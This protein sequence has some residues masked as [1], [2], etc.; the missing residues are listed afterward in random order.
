MEVSSG[1]RTL[2]PFILARGHTLPMP[3][4]LSIRRG[5]MRAQAGLCAGTSLNRHAQTATG[6]CSSMRLSKPIRRRFGCGAPSAFRSL[7]RCRR[8]FVTRHT[9]T[10]ASISCTCR[11]G[12]KRPTHSASP[13]VFEDHG[14]DGQ[15]GK[16]PEV[17]ILGLRGRRAGTAKPQSRA[18]RAGMMA[19]WSMMAARTGLD[20]TRG[21]LAVSCGRCCWPRARSQGLART[22]WRSTRAAARA[23]M[24]WSCWLAAGRSWR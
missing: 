1:A 19:E 21:Q 12:T 13:D 11:F 20:T 16:V 17:T 6:R 15:A 18:A 10:L 7:P 4:L 22:A 14:G 24:R 9:D 3:A 2:I 5:A 23:P 8:H